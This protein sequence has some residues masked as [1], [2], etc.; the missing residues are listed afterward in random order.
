MILALITA[1]GSG[2]HQPAAMPSLISGYLIL[3][4]SNKNLIPIATIFII[5]YLNLKRLRRRPFTNGTEKTSPVAIQHQS[6][7]TPVK[8]N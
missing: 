1:I 4:Y 5:G 8:V 3:G 6:L 7:I 2:Q